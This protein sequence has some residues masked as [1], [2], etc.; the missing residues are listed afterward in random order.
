MAL[1]ASR[2]FVAFPPFSF[3]PKAALPSTGAL[4]AREGFFLGGVITCV[5]ASPLSTRVREN[6]RD[7]VSLLCENASVTT[8]FLMRDDL[9]SQAGYKKILKTFNPI[10]SGPCT[11]HAFCTLFCSLE[12]PKGIRMECD[13]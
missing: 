11:V 6:P 8:P 1:L 13:F 9:P 12:T 3:P 4:Q 2:S 10:F 7:L 5:L